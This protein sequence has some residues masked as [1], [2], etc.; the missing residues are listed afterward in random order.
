MKKLFTGAALFCVLSAPLF[1]ADKQSAAAENNACSGIVT[2]AAD[3]MY[4]FKMGN[5]DIN[6]RNK[7]GS[8]TF[9]EF[10]AVS[11]VFSKM[12]GD[13]LIDDQVA[14]TFKGITFRTYDAGKKEWVVRWLPA[15]STFAP[16]I[17]AK[18]ENCVPVERH[19]QM[20]RGGKMAKVRT[21]FTNITAD[22][23]EF[24]QDWSLDEGETWIE[25]VLYYEAVRQKG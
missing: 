21:S 16:N 20:A 17:S 18:L 22:R 25:D 1:A 3:R 15:G 5:W 19:E 23:F 9:S 24:H 14:E 13:I 2:E 12:D 6:W 4:D 10:T 8:G 7:A 11:T